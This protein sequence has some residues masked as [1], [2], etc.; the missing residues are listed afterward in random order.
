MWQMSQERK[1]RAISIVWFGSIA[2]ITSTIGTVLALVSFILRDPEAFVEKSLK[3]SSTSPSVAL[4]SL[5]QNK[6]A[7]IAFAASVNL[8]DAFDHFIR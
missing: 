2:L 1:S 8:F 6:S 7:A 4:C 5:R 3:P